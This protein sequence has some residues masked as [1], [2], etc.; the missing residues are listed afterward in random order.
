MLPICSCRSS[1]I[2]IRAL[3]IWIMV[4][5]NDWSDNSSIY[6]LHLNQV[7]LLVLI[8]EMCWGG[9][10]SLSFF[11]LLFLVI[12]LGD[13]FFKSFIVPFNLLL[14]TRHDVPWKGTEVF[15][16]V[17][18]DFRFIWLGFGVVYYLLC[19]SEAKISSGV[20]AFVSHVIFRST[21]ETCK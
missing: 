11:P 21:I 19:L 8:P 7:L 5:L 9:G 16:P 1:I 3:S 14:N 4:A 20:L 10:F 2:S 15:R 12:F 13:V 6:L 17:V 18:W